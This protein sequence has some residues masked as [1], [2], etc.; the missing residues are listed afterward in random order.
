MRRLNLCSSVCARSASQFGL[1][2]AV[3]VFLTSCGGGGGGGG[4][5]PPIQLA[6]VVTP[7]AATIYPSSSFTVLVTASTNSSSQPSLTSVTMPAGITTTESFPLAIP[8]GG[9]S[10]QFQTSSSIAAGNYTLT[11]SGTLGSMSSTAKLVATVQTNPPSFFF[12]SPLFSEIAVPVG[13]SSQVQVSTIVNGQA[14]YNVQLSLS[15]LPPGTSATISP[16]TITVGQSATVTITAASTA[17]LEQN[18]SI[19]LT[20]T[21]AAPV[22]AASLGFLLDVAPKSGSLLNNRTDYVSTEHTPFAAVYDPTHQLIF[23]SNDSWNRVE[24]I[25]ST[26]HAL[27]KRI[28][29]P[30]PR[31][32]DITQ[33]HSTIW[34]TTGSRQMF[35]INTTTFEV[36]RYLLPIEGNAS[37]WEGWQVFVLSDGSMM[38]VS[39]AG[40]FTGSFGI[41]IW[42]P[43]TNAI[44]FPTILFPLDNTIY[45]RSGD[46]KRAY[47]FNNHTGGAVMYYDVASQTFSSS[48]TV[49]VAGFN[50]AVNT[51]GSRFILCNDVGGFVYDGSYNQLGVIPPC[52][53]GVAPFFEGGAVFS[54]DGKF[55]YE[56]VLA[57]IPQILKIDANTLNL[58]S[59]APAMPMIP[60]MTELSPPYYVPNPFAVDDTGMVFGIEF[61]GIALDD[62]TYAQSYSPVQPGTPIFLQHMDPY[63]GPPGGGTTSG[64]F[65]N[66]FSITPDVWYGSV[67]GTAS[68][69]AGGDLAITSPTSIMA[70]PVNIKMIFP[71]GIEVFDPLFFSYGPYLQYPLVSGGPPQGNVAGQVAGYGMPG[72]NISGTFS[73]GGATA[74]VAPPGPFGVPFAGTPYPNKVLSYTLPPGP[75]GWAD[76]KLT[77]PDGTSTLSHAF[78][79]AKSLT[80]YASTDTFTAVLYDQTRRQLYLSAGD[81]VDVFSLQSNTF[82]AKW[83]PPAAGSAKQFTGLALTPDGSLLLAADLLDGSLAVF[84]PDN[85]ATSFVIPVT[86]VQTGNPGCNIGPLYVAGLVNKTAAVQTGGLPSSQG[87]CPPYGNV[88]LVDLTTHAV[89]PFST[90][91]VSIALSATNDGSKLAYGGMCVYDAV[92]N[93][94]SCSGAAQTT[95]PAISGDGH[96]VASEFVLADGVA[97]VLGRVARPEVYYSALG[98]DVAHTLLLEPKLNDSGSLYYLAFPNFIDIVD[99]R[100]GILRIRFSLSETISNTATPMAID[101]SGRYLYL[102]T[103]SG[104]TIIDLGEAP[105]SIGW[106]SSATASPGTQITVRGSGFNTSTTAMVGGQIASVAFVDPN[107]LTLTVPALSTGPTTIVLSSSDGQI[108]TATGLL[109]IP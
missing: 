62:S 57:N 72:D 105:L 64:G 77:T 16:P 91:S 32:I 24:V 61:W 48:T 88:F 13:G 35:A 3:V 15:G 11:F 14:A 26:T 93:S 63:F 85:P 45:N 8:S 20:G 75:P 70:G 40:Q 96:A 44:N 66:A 53:P 74:S 2:L 46:G 30:E 51:D 21:P 42:N 25:S 76:L 94:S 36:S 1:F 97:N 84:S 29:I 65:G 47:L 31:G 19:T 106:L 92:A 71:D 100:Q 101:P 43:A 102:I 59:T 107:T 23:A 28:S 83:N 17:A 69:G 103:A 49:N 5:P 54:A 79:Y 38:I 39:T 78:L 104:L 80:D 18:V 33:D 67:Q 55:I 10:I 99:F 95:S 60:V 9:V 86:P 56:E 7:S 22:P 108:Y 89:S 98:S 34:V 12:P 37:Y 50:S 68:L 81:H 82:I 73:V 87:G 6:I 27:V 109:T 90:S 4:T 58:V 41:V 52:G